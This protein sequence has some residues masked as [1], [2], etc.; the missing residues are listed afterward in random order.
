[1]TEVDFHCHVCGVEVPS[2]PDPPAKAV[3]EDHC[4]DHDYA[5][6]PGERQHLCIHCGKPRPQDWCDD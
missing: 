4:E 3:C 5:Y 1:M 6:E 2:A